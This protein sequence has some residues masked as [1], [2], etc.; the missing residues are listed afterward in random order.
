MPHPLLTQDAASSVPI[1]LVT[2]ESWPGMAGRLPSPCRSFAA[3]QGFDG[4]AGTHC[5]LPNGDGTLAGVAFGLE[6]ADAR[7]A[8]P[9][10]PG[11]LPSL[12]PDGLYRLEASGD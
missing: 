9:F 10:L 5:L 1:W 4:K 6:G 3:A 8:D 2:N 7:R 12:L 11:K